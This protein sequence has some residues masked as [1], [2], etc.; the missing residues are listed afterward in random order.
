MSNDIADIFRDLEMNPEVRKEIQNK[1]NDFHSMLF[2][3]K[4]LVTHNKDGHHFMSWSRHYKAMEEKGLIKI[5]R[6]AHPN[7]MLYGRNHWS[8]EI[9]DLGKTFVRGGP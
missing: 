8:A 2:E 1:L 4:I 6:P 7:G 3:L 9:T 5:N